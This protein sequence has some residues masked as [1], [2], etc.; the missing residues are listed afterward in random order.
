[1]RS[2]GRNGR[3]AR[4][5]ASGLAVIAALTA[6]CGAPSGGPV[7]AAVPTGSAEAEAEI[8]R[9]V[10]EALERDA[11]WSDAADLFA[12]EPVI[13]ADG[14]RRYTYPLFA[15]IDSGGQVGITTSLIE[16]G[17]TL[18]WMYVEY[19]WLAPARGAAAAGRATFV[20]APA[21]GEQPWSIVHAHS[22]TAP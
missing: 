21:R 4:L 16:I 14:E 20:L 1:M 15:A 10:Q 6:G 7:M 12:A 18:A 2:T 19:R 22:S 8:T 11:A 3:Q 17:P 13:I 9:V 5:T